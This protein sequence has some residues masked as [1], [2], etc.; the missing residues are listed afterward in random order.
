MTDAM[1][2]VVLDG[3][4]GPEVMRLDRVPRPLIRSTS[5]A[6]APA[7]GSPVTSSP[8]LRSAPYASATCSSTSRI[9]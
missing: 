4:G 9:T 8:T 7:T 6:T 1:R 3:F 2:A 5:V